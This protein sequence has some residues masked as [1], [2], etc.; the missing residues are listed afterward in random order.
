MN[1][2]EDFTKNQA[3]LQAAHN[4]QMMQYEE[5]AKK[6]NMENYRKMLDQ[7]IN[8]RNQFKM[9]GNMTSVEKALN[10]PELEAYKNYDN[11]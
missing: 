2:T 10:R 3:R 6:K 4:A 9:Y 1:D 11:N 7:Q 8:I 5:F